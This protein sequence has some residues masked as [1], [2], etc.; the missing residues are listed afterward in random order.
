MNLLK[1]L[2]LKENFDNILLIVLITFLFKEG[3][4][5]MITIIPLVLLLVS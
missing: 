3:G 1:N 2:D 5:D 4:E